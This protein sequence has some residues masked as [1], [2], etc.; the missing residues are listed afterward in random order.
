MN[1]TPESGGVMV[2]ESMFQLELWH[3]PVVAQAEKVEPIV[4]PTP[5]KVQLIAIISDAISGRDAAVM[6][7]PD[8]DEIRSVYVGSQIG[9]HDVS[10]ITQDAVELAN[11]AR[12][13]RIKLETVEFKR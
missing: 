12:S 1:T 4:K 2:S 3:T 13:Q 8:R 6:Y 9:G 7:D 11:G 5:L 10:E